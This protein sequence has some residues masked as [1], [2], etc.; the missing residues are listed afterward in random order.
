MR[1][2]CPRHEGRQGPSEAAFALV[3]CLL[4]VAPLETQAEA[5]LKDCRNIS[6]AVSE[7]DTV[8][9]PLNTSKMM[10]V[11]KWNSSIS[12]WE[13]VLIYNGK[14]HSGKRP[15]TD[16]LTVSQEQFTVMNVSRELQGVYMVTLYLS[17]K[18]VALINLTARAPMAPPSVIPGNEAPA[19]HPALWALF[20]TLIIAAIV[21]Y[22]AVKRFC[23][24]RDGSRASVFYPVFR[25][26]GRNPNQNRRM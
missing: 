9:I 8:V 7:G 5:D 17:E 11:Y 22:L 4:V 12:T 25:R 15:F 19:A 1:S 21:I 13:L 14:S 16:Q 10:D 3:L 18:C 20:P 6:R 26:R 23:P 24:R 2:T